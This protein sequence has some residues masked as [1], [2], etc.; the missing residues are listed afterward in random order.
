[1]RVALL[2]IIPF[3]VSSYAF[4]ETDTRVDIP[5]IVQAF[6]D[7]LQNQPA[8]G[9]VSW[10]NP[11][12]G[13]YGAVTAGEMR[14]GGEGLCRNFTRTW[15]FD[16]GTTTFSGW[17]CRKPNGLWS[18]KEDKRQSRVAA[19][20]RPPTPPKLMANLDGASNRLD[21]AAPSASLTAVPDDSDG[22]QAREGGQ[23]R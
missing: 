9:T 23:G 11:G 20:P 18:A 1:M 3:A 14:A 10:E 4:A 16:G 12:N 6:N 19:L 21:P 7:A 22:S 15:T 13:H 5:Y 17:A 2:A 8:G